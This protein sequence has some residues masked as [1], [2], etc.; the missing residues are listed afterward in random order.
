MKKIYIIFVC[1]FSL[2]SSHYSQFFFLQAPDPD[3]NPTESDCVSITN[4]LRYR[5]RDANTNGEVSTLQDFLQSKGYLNSEP[6]GYFGLLTF[7]AVKD[8]QKD[9]NI[10]PT[11]YVGPVT[12]AKIQTLTL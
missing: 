6:T 12:R 8:F 11:G 2:R 4:N 3:P 7:K 10:S 1:G 9:N 5:A